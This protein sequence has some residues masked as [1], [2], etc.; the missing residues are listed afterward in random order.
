M[1]QGGLGLALETM[2]LGVTVTDIDRRILYTNPAE[3]SMHGY[4]VDELIGQ[5][6][7][8]FAPPSHSRNVPQDQLS[9]VAWRREGINVR[10]DG[11]TFPVR[12]LSRVVRT[13][14]HDQVVGIVTTCEDITEHI[15][16]VK[17]LQSSERRFRSF[18]ERAAHGIYRATPAG[19]FLEV[20]PALVRMLGYVSA[21]EVIGLDLAR[22]VS[23]DP[24]RRRQFLAEIRDGAPRTGI[25]VQWKTKDGSVIDVRLSGNAVYD[26]QGD[27]DYV[28]MFAEDVTEHEVLKAQLRRAQKMELLGQWTGGMAHDF[29]NILTVI[30]TN[31]EIIASTLPPERDDLREELDGLRRAAERGTAMVRK[32]LSFGKGRRMAL[33]AVDLRR[34]VDDLLST[35]RRLVPETIEI[36]IRH[37]EDLPLV[38][39]DAGVVEQILLNL[40]TN[41]RDAMT[42]GGTLRIATTARKLEARHRDAHGWGTPGE[43][44]CIAVSD[45]G[46]GMDGDAVEK[47]FEPFFTTKEPGSGTGLG[48][49]MVY[50]LMKQHTGFVDVKSDPGVGTT[51]T[52]YFPVSDAEEEEPQEPQEPVT[53]ARGTEMVLIVEDEEPIRRATKRLLERYGYTALLATD[54]EEALRVLEE[55]GTNVQLVITDFVMPRMTGPQL[56][57]AVRER[58]LQT[59]FI[60]VS[61]YSEDADET[62]TGA[63]NDVPF[64]RKP[65]APAALLAQVREVLDEGTG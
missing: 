30:L 21:E 8:I 54:G 11:S 50:G 27:F 17:A 6:S 9:E 65:W 49:A 42:D 41:A 1:L 4:T 26:G 57:A 25:E 35:L 32:L 20:N 40:A 63:R 7:R 55:R 61:G 33:E 31:A 48:M 58:G 45:S 12:L 51:V 46:V 34:T 37:A 24:E 10:R 53:H 18:V 19:R 36:Q 14:S 64:L 5:P 15:R 43:Y 59:R 28:E 47:I 22:D 60:M 29:N 16:S 38:K 23:V 3:A 44:V 13:S 52:V 62:R 2:P 39:A 56:Y